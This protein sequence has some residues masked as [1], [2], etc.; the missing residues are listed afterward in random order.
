M[1]A[2]GTSLKFAV[3]SAAAFAVLGVS[4][5]ANAATTIVGVGGDGALA[6]ELAPGQAA[7]I[8]FTLSSAISNANLYADLF[9]ANCTG[10]ILLL[11][12]DIGPTATFANVQRVLDYDIATPI[13]PLLSGLDLDPGTYFLVLA[14]TGSQGGAAWLASKP[15]NFTNSAIGTVGFDVFASSVGTIPY[16]ADFG[17]TTD[18]K[19][20]HFRLETASV[21]PPPGGIPEPASWAMMLC[22]F[23]LV[24]AG[25]RRSHSIVSLPAR[26]V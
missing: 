24:G 21:T 2:F 10:T 7:G 15:A 23:G 1:T 17:I 5:T 6:Q 18:G 14:L 12:D 4:A 20:M 19:A 11:K 9:C 16:Q 25:L 22:G 3:F 8:S 13:S 26:Q